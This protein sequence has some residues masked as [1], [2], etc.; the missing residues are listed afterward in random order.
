MEKRKKMPILQM[1]LLAVCLIWGINLDAA[2]SP[3]TFLMPR[4]Q[5]FNLAMEYSTWHSHAY[6]PGES[7]YHG[8]FRITSYYQ[9]STNGA[10]VGK[11]FVGKDR[12]YFGI[13]DESE[14]INSTTPP[15]FI[16][17][18][19]ITV[20]SDIETPDMSVY[21]SPKQEVFGLRIDYLQ[22]LSLLLKGAYFKV[23]FPLVYLNN[24]MNASFVKGERMGESS[25]D[26]MKSYFHGEVKVD[27]EY[28]R[29]GKIPRK[30]MS[31]GGVADI[32]LSF[33]Y[34][35]ISS[36]NHHLFFNVDFVI[37]TGNKPNAEYLFEPIYGN[38]RH[39]GLGWGVDA[40][41]RLWKKEKHQGRLLG[42]FKHVY[43]FERN[44]KRLSLIGGYESYT[45]P[46]LINN[47]AKDVKVRPG[48]NL[49]FLGMFSFESSRFILD[50]GY[51]FFY[52]QAESI[53][54]NI[55]LSKEKPFLSD[56]AKNVLLKLRVD[57][58]PVGDLGHAVTPSCK[59][60]K[61]FG[62]VAYKFMV[63]DKYPLS[64][65]IGGSYEFG[66]HIIA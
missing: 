19:D 21:F 2:T 5:L 25:F 7:D 37:P 33:G 59:T 27:D 46:D 15:D 52:K 55:D 28:L 13:I 39:F 40:A 4:S 20:G 24:K 54:G 16:V 14:I 11:Y 36:P 64:L 30:T 43:L 63:Q 53:S 32:E 9:H 61:L 3:K 58:N 49:N 12:N 44:E 66:G 47:L 60:H 51:D 38:G 50:L 62:A 48:N 1:L 10:D 45:T 8:H 6:F 23:S 41:V 22:N 65:G 29:Y 56:S 34:K 17:L 35:Y 26:N 31:S 57:N 42:V 18:D